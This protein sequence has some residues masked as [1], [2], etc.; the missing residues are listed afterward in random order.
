MVYISPHLCLSCLILS[1]LIPLT[2]SRCTGRRLSG[3]VMFPIKNFDFTFDRLSSRLASS[4]R[5]LRP[6]YWSVSLLITEGVP[7]LFEATHFSRFGEHLHRCR[8]KQSSSPRP[9]AV[10]RGWMELT[11]SIRYLRWFRYRLRSSEFRRI[12]TIFFSNSL[13]FGD[14]AAF[15][16]GI[17]GL[18]VL[19]LVG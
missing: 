15:V 5:N 16:N 12:A 17:S 6:L 2:V 10:S 7:A 1:H 9:R 14:I 11:R 18:M 19:V 13:I 3:V 4:L 8:V